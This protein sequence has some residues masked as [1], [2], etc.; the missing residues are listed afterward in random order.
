[1]M[2]FICFAYLHNIRFVHILLAKILSPR[3]PLLKICL[4]KTGIQSDIVV[5][6]SSQ[7]DFFVPISP[8]SPS[9]ETYLEE[10]NSYEDKGNIFY[11]FTKMSASYLN[12]KHDIM[13]NFIEPYEIYCNCN[14]IPRQTPAKSFENDLNGEK[15]VRRCAMPFL[16][17]FY[18]ICQLILALRCEYFV[19]IFDVD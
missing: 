8:S 17:N 10:S 14:Y 13:E 5:Q 12:S 11:F 4:Q 7:G 9:S 15:E 16:F 2:L 18:F 1:M 3:F 19:R 6:P